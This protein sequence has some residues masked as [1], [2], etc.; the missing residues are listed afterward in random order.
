MRKLIEQ[1]AKFGVVGVIAFIIDY[2]TM[3][4]LT[5]IFGVPYL[6]STTV[7]FIVSVIFN[8][9]AS[10]KYVFARR[11]DIGRAREFTVFVVLSVI[12]LGLNDVLMW[13]FV[14]M[15]GGDYRL[16]KILVTALVMVYNFVTR[17]IFLEKHEKNATSSDE[18]INLG[19]T[20]E[21]QSQLPAAWADGPEAGL[22][23][24]E[25]L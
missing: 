11:D 25:T 17:K 22:G 16:M 8:Y 13:G 9:L 19:N 6:I 18:S 14:D 21:N 5:E 3:I 12:G 7:G 24:E 20:T 1:I 4:A 23:R 2:G 10:M 15:L